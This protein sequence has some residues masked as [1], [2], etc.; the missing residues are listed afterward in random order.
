[1][2]DN[3][4][5]GGGGS[6]DDEGGSTFSDIDLSAFLTG[7]SEADGVSFPIATGINVGRLAAAIVGS[8]A[9]GIAFGFSTLIDGLVT[10]YT[11]IV[12]RFASYVSTLIGATLGAGASAIYG[13]WSFTLDEFGVFAYVVAIGVFVLTAYVADRGI[14]AA[15]EVL[16]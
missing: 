6:P 7:S 11:L 12:D 5:E 15:R 16:F 1:M 4:L 9:Y 8:I 14:N 13:A 10:G 2:A 3:N